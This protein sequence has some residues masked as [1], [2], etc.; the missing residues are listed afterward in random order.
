M[1]AS[2]APPQIREQR[3]LFNGPSAAAAEIESSQQIN[4]EEDTISHRQKRSFLKK[5]IVVTSSSTV[6]ITSYSISASTVTK[7]ITLGIGGCA[8]CVS[9]L[10][11]G[12]TIC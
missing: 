6:T 9:C 3:D 7:S 12:V 8:A 11:S 2:V 4:D 1:E 5:Y 10:P